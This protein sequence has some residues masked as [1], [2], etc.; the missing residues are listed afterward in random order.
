[1]VGASHHDL[2]AVDDGRHDAPWVELHVARIEG[3]VLSD[4]DEVP[5]GLEP[6]LGDEQGNDTGPVRPREVV[7]V[8]DDGAILTTPA[9]SAAMGAS[10]FI[11]CAFRV[12][13]R[14]R[15]SEPSAR[16]GNGVALPIPGCDEKRL[17][18]AAT[19]RDSRRPGTH[20]P[21][22]GEEGP[23]GDRFS[24]SG[25]R[26]DLEL[27]CETWD[28]ARRLYERN[29]APGSMWLPVDATAARGRVSVSIRLPSGDRARVEGSVSEHAAPS[30][31]VLRVRFE[32]LS[33]ELLRA[34][35]QGLGDMAIRDVQT[36]RVGP[37]ITSPPQSG[38]KPRR[39]SGR[40]AGDRTRH[41]RR[42]SGAS[43]QAGLSLARRV[44]AALICRLNTPA[45]DPPTRRNPIR[46]A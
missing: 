12:T 16:V 32:P 45:P 14:H 29:L 15:V 30:G 33:P 7:V 9:R 19:R 18:L 21:G 3:R 23:S 41:L 6:L 8:H 2:G 22:T 26:A 1:M 28:K 25:E 43:A 13:L 34:L 20:P 36:P 10:C 31:P 27:S 44:P 17:E 46:V 39:A 4:V 35:R 24:A 5:G 42:A 38:T 37:P 11:S 40:S